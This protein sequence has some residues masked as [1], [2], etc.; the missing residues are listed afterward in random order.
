MDSGVEGRVSVG[1]SME[2]LQKWASVAAASDIPQDYGAKDWL[3]IL[4]VSAAHSGRAVPCWGYFN[5]GSAPVRCLASVAR[6]LSTLPI[7]AAF[8]RVYNFK[9]V[10]SNVFATGTM[11]ART[12][13]QAAERERER[14]QQAL[15]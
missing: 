13:P 2:H 10:R 4:K 15:F 8:Q 6:L 9:L 12:T 1:I 14:E 7:A 5:A 11:R 3:L